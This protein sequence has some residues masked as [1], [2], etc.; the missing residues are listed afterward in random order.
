[1]VEPTLSACS[2]S[3]IIARAYDRVNRTAHRTPKKKRRDVPWVAVV[4]G[5]SDYATPYP[6]C[7]SLT[8]KHRIAYHSNAMQIIAI[9]NHK[10]GVAKTA[11][12]HSLG[13]LLS[14]DRRVLLVD[15]DPQA[16]LTGACGIPDAPG[17]S[18]AEV[19]GG[20]D[21][22]RLALSDVILELSERLSL[23]PSDLALAQSERGLMQRLSREAVLKRALATVARSY[24]LAILDCPPSLGLLV[25]NALVASDGVLIPCQ[26]TATDIRSV[27]GFLDVVA[28]VQ[29]INP[30]LEVVGILPTFYAGH[31]TSHKAA[32][33]AMI[34]A[35][36][37]LL[38]TRIGR[39][40]RVSEASAIGQA[41]TGE[42]H[43]GID[44]G[45]DNVLGPGS[46]V[47]STLQAD[48]GHIPLIERVVGI[49]RLRQCMNDIVGLGIQDRRIAP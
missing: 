14:E 17:R 18:L 13:V 42:V 22:G 1:M 30:R 26:P 19:I 47:P 48:V 24:D 9:A 40:V 21:P 32:L 16:S 20:A 45:D 15:C 49:V 31:Y 37:P 8:A 39:S 5:A 7:R 11:T 36:L 25:I 12:A 4:R 34:R 23:V 28:S 33:D 43:T 35:G 41:V 46:S 3:G 6:G 29:E 2:F 38:N 10:G 27:Q 44:H